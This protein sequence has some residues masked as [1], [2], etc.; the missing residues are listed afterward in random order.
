MTCCDLIGGLGPRRRLYLLLMLLILCGTRAARAQYVLEDV[1]GWGTANPTVNTY[2]PVF[3]NGGT[4]TITLASSSDV[5][6]LVV[7]ATPNSTTLDMTSFDNTA[8]DN[9]AATRLTYPYKVLVTGAA[10]ATPM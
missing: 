1:T 2:S 10:P 6:L 8:R 5:V 9:Q 3:A 7:T 4:G